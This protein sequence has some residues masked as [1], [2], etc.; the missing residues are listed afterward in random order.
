[1]KS[2][3]VMNDPDTLST[4]KFNI[5]QSRQACSVGFGVFLFLFGWWFISCVGFVYRSSCS[6]PSVPVAM[7]QEEY[8][9][10]LFLF[11]GHFKLM[12][13]LM[14]SFSKLKAVSLQ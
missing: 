7:K 4:F 3:L 13:G 2:V 5:T 9:T 14:S 6:F 1:M 11:T 10:V 12:S 8:N